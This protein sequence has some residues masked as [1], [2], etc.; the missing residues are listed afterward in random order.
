MNIL[1]SQSSGMGF[2][3]FSGFF[4]FFGTAR[5]YRCPEGEV[6]KSN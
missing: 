2:P 3:A 6:K 5:H 4:L 1:C